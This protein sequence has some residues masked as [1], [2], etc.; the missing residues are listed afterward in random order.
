MKERRTDITAREEEIRRRSVQDVY[1][2]YE[3]AKALGA[4]KC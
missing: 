4:K 1:E 3:H 2:L